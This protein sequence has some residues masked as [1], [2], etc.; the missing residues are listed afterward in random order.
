MTAIPLILD[1]AT[2][3]GKTSAKLGIGVLLSVESL[4]TV[5]TELVDIAILRWTGLVLS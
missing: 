3:V 5:A 1:T 4:S 2:T